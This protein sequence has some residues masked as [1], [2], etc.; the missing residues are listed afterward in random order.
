M[1]TI[2]KHMVQLRSWG[3]YPKVLS[4]LHYINSEKIPSSLSNKEYV[5]YGNGRSYGDCALQ[6]DS[7]QTIK[8]NKIISFDLEKGIFRCQSGILLSDILKRIIPEKWFLPVTPGTKYITIGGAI[9]SDVHGKNHHKKGCFSDHIISLQ[10]LLP[11]GT[12]ITCSKTKNIEIFKAT[13]GGMGLTGIILQATIQLIPIKSAFIDQQVLQVKNLE[14]IFETFD[15][16]KN[17][18]YSVA[19]IDAT[20]KTSELGKGLFFIGE[21]ANDQNFSFSFKQKI[22]IPKW[23]PSFLLNPFSIKLYNKYYY[24]KFLQV[25]EKISIDTFFY[26]LDAIK[27]WNR[28]YGTKGFLQYQVIIPKENSFKGM[29]ELLLAVA[30]SQHT[31]Y[32]TVLKSLGKENENLLSFPLEGYT[33]AMDFKIKKGLLEFL[34][35]LDKIVLQYGGRGYMAKDVRMSKDFFEAGYSKIKKFKNLRKQYNLEQLQSLQSKRLGL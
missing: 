23:F 32:L 2:P 1:S 30:S 4:Q 9:A 26:P 6:I 31:S 29:G 3:N 25:S 35:Q 34:E 27:N 7:I 15:K 33:I 24:R 13:C 21:H 5:P 28:I 16:Y 19:W 14:N 11:D 12:I 17:A 22:S 18:T 10:L 20:T 8:S